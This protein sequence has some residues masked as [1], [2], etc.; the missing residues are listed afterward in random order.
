MASEHV[1]AY[2]SEDQYA[3]W[4]ERREEMDMGKSEFVISMVEAGMKKIDPIVNPDE[5]VRRLRDQRIELG[6]ELRQC[7]S[8]RRRLENKIDGMRDMWHHTDREALRR[9]VVDN[10]GT[11]Y[12][13]AL[14]HIE[15]TAPQRVGYHLD[16]MTGEHI[17]DKQDGNVVRYYPVETE[18]Q[19]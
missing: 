14:E 1:N 3:R 19:G 12:S 9:F 8:E 4:E 17:R 15:S 2:P 11:T 13:E 18:V 6:E 10:P 16:A 5:E 7:Q